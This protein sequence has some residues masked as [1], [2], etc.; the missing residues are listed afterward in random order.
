V[1]PDDRHWD[2]LR[3]L[4]YCGKQIGR[5]DSVAARPAG[6]QE[7]ELEQQLRGWRHPKLTAWNAR[8]NPEMFFERLEDLVRV[9]AEIAHDLPEHVPFNLSERQTDVLIREQRVLAAARFVEGT[10]NDALG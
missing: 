4:E 8:Q 1:T 3:F 9:Q 7:G 2:A 10:I 5:L 6:V